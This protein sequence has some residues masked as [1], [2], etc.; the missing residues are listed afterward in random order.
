MH[1]ICFQAKQEQVGGDLKGDGMQTGGTVVVE[2]GMTKEIAMHS[3]G[4]E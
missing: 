4:L 2:K 1:F 3:I